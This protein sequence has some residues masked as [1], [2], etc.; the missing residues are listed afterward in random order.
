MSL[1]GPGP[2]MSECQDP[3]LP[4]LYCCRWSVYISAEIWNHHPDME[5]A[6]VYKKRIVYII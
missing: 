5:D 6:S 2:I 3:G 1:V 4:R